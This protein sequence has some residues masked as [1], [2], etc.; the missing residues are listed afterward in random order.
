MIRKTSQTLILRDAKWKVGILDDLIDKGYFLSRGEAYRIGA[1]IVLLSYK[2]LKR[3]EVKTLC[4]QILS[5]IFRSAIETLDDKDTDRLIT[6]L[7]CIYD[8]A[9]ILSKIADLNPT[10]YEMEISKLSDEILEII[11]GLKSFQE[12]KKLN[13]TLTNIKE[14]LLKIA[15]KYNL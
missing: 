9:K 7:H 11:E 2:Y 6:K 4:Q 8:R 1:S 14:K 15:E 3:D 13:V 10:I 12:G 5:D